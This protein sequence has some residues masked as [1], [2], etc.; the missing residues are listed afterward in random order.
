MIEFLSMSLN[1]KIVGLRQRTQ[2]T[3]NQYVNVLFIDQVPHQALP[4]SEGNFI[5]IS[6]S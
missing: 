2:L 4:S 1:I 5:P 3:E 6:W